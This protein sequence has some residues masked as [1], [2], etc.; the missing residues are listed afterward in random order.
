MERGQM[1]VQSENQKPSGWSFTNE[2]NEQ[3]TRVGPGT[4]MGDLFRQYW[5]A[6]VPASFLPKSDGK[7]LRIRLLCED[8][9]LFRTGKGKIGLVGAYC[10]HRLAPLFFGRIEDDGIR[11]PYHGWK[12]ATDGQCM[13]MPNIPR[14]QQ[15]CSTI[16]HPGYPCVE[17]GGI[18]WTY[19]GS[20]KDMPSL[21]E[22]EF[23]EVPDDQRTYRMFHHQCNYLQVLEG[24]IDPTHVMWLHSPY[25]LADDISREHQ[26][27]QQLVANQSGMRTP[28][29]IE[30]VDTA[31]GF[32]YGAKRSVGAGKVL[33]RVSQFIMPF[34]SMPPGSELRGARIYTPIDDENSIKWQIGWYPTREIMQSIKERDRMNF[35]EEDFLPSTGEP[36]GFIRSKA[37]KAND[38]LIDWDIHRTKRFGISGVN[39]QDQCVTENE[40]PTAI[41]DRTKENLCSADYATIKARRL[42]LNAAK[43]L[44]ERGAPSP[45]IRDPRIYRI[46]GTSKIIS[47]STPWVE[48]VK[49]D[50]LLEGSTSLA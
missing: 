7:P 2:E 36:Y 44:R 1:T 40:G 45:G 16:R 14:E 34:Y 24:G 46:R 43:V 33:W 12:Y 15:F 31:G 48:G 19:M 30:F 6:V 17:Y 13:E 50:V 23:T 29:A 26:P 32:M 20:T 11:C 41:L 37:N 22:F 9:V 8:L 27:S 25:N 21:P 5:I 3:L 39:L 35:D 49:S 10:Q 47:E 4:L 18:I 38:Y 28:M 42:L